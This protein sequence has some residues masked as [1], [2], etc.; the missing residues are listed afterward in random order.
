MQRRALGTSGLTFF[1]LGLGGMPMSIQGRPPEAQSLRTLAA[2]LDAGMDFVDTA[3]VYCLDDSDLGHNEALVAEG[4]RQWGGERRIFVAT[5]GGCTRPGGRWGV[6]GRPDR[7]KAACERSLKALRVERID[8]YQLHA[9]DDRVRF[10]DSVGALADLQR[11]GK[12]AHLGLSNVSVAQIEAAAGI[13]PIVSVQ[14][15]LNPYDTT[16]LRDGVVAHC[17]AKNI[18]FLAYSPVGGGRGV[19]RLRADPR[20]L[21]IAQRHPGATAPQI[22]LAWLLA[23]SK[24]ILPIPGAS[25]PAN[26][27]SSARAA[28]LALSATDLA[29]LDRAFLGHG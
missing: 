11:A 19:V 7:L 14:N 3:N 24:V 16:A 27:T 28:A 9:P 13:A 10:E 22:A 20:L 5:K 17:E 2:A 15:R 18:A 23:K 29:E 12:V 4:I 21:A 8:L 26:A 25:K 6:D 1:P